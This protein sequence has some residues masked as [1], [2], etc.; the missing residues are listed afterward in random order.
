[1]EIVTNR[2]SQVE[3]DL[4]DDII[5]ITKVNERNGHAKNS[6]HIA[7]SPVAKKVEEVNRKS[8]TSSTRWR[9][10]DNKIFTNDQRASNQIQG[11]QK[12]IKDQSKIIRPGFSCAWWGKPLVLIK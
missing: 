9:R 5:T 6:Q 1:M 2:C 11:V 4:L 7:I 8:W 3:S 12:R 10:L